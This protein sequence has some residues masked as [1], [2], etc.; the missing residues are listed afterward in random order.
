MLF[1]MSQTLRRDELINR[2]GVVISDQSAFHRPL[3]GRLRHEPCP[4]KKLPCHDRRRLSCGS[5]GDG[6]W[7]LKRDGGVVADLPPSR[8]VK[9]PHRW[10]LRDLL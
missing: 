6:H 8:R 1:F 4:Y 10:T 5:V 7:I 3:D 9:K 2:I